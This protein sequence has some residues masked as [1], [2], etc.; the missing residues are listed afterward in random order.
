MDGVAPPD[1]GVEEARELGIADLLEHDPRPAFITEL[2]TASSTKLEIIFLNASLRSNT[3]LS[4]QIKGKVEG[5]EGPTAWRRFRDW[6]I[7]VMEHG[8][9]GS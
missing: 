5:A 2:M 1:A 7:Q 6:A 9:S 8:R 3:T 4:D